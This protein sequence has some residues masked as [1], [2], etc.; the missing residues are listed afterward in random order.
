MIIG[1]SGK[2][3]SGKDT[4]AKIFQY[5]TLP[6]SVRTI[7]LQEWVTELSYN[8][9][10]PNLS[11][12]LENRKFADKLKECVALLTGLQRWQLE[13][14]EVKNMVLPAN[15]NRWELHTEF[16]RSIYA[17]KEEALAVVKI[18]KLK[19]SEY[20][21]EEVPLTIR[22]FLQEFGTEGVRNNIHPNAWVN[23]TLSDYDIIDTT[24]VTALK[25]ASDSVE[26]FELPVYP[27]WIITD[28]RFPN[29]VEAIQYGV[30]GQPA[31][32]QYDL[33]YTIRVE[34]PAILQQQI[35][36]EHESETALDDYEDWDTV[37]VNDCSLEELGFKVHEIL[38]SN[39]K[40][41]QY[42]HI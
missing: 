3:G 38:K 36:D 19:K 34:R 30:L 4:V 8:S 33:R 39:P 23:A 26:V 11:R 25:P 41:Q 27:A 42:F 7:S 31:D 2:K 9:E 28:V 1:L 10:I 40:F 20:S 15:W 16:E 5:F 17:T 37:L 32:E 22:T 13:L 35:M 29:E 24:T 18:L 21:L 12:Y 6:K 14:E